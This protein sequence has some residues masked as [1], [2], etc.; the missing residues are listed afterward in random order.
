MI[1]KKLILFLTIPLLLLCGC[2]KVTDEKTFPNAFNSTAQI[3]FGDMKYVA[4]ISRY[5]D[6]Q[7]VVEFLEPDAVK[8]LI[9]TIQGEDS[10]ISFNGLHFVFDTEKFPVG[11]VVS[12]I[13]KS[14]DKVIACGLEFLEG[15]EI[16]TATGQIDGLSY[17]I[18]FDKNENP[19]SIEFSDSG[20]IL[21]FTEFE[22]I[23][24]ENNE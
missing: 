18:A 9:F 20:L 19:L 16:D 6:S 22:L 21:N 7:Y 15:E 13:T 4:T 2:E 5:A 23:E 17:K 12:I 11:S 3:T 14:L 10:E 24:E 1:L 8:G